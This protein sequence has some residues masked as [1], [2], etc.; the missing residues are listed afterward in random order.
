MQIV[1]NLIKLDNKLTHRHK[2]HLE[3]EILQKLI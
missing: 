3:F 2:G 1:I